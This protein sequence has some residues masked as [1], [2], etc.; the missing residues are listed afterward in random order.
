MAIIGH[1][2]RAARIA[3]L[4]FAACLPAAAGAETQLS[5]AALRGEHVFQAAAGCSC[6]TD[7][8]NDGPP[9]AGG[10]ALDTP[11]GTF[12][13]PNITPHPGT[14][15]GNWDQADFVRAMTTGTG[16]QGVHYY[17]AFPYTSYTRMTR[18]DLSDLWAYLATREPVERR[19]REHDLAWPFSWRYLLSWWQWWYL[20]DPG[21]AADAVTDPARSEQWNRGAYLVNGPSHCG[22]CHTPRGWF[23]GLDHSMAL[24]GTAQGPEGEL[25]P[26]ITPDPE[27]GIGNWTQADLAWLLQTGLLP[28][29]DSVQGAMAEAI[30]QGYSALPA[31][32]RNAIAA[33]LLA[34]PPIHNPLQ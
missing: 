18:Q 9:L 21:P 20:D 22:E 30:D 19:N 14:G 24:A 15:L 1:R 28:D 29:G 6:H 16:P 2:H 12:Y 10:R 27:T 25:V 17:P 8:P 7:L 4:V 34:R 11:F 3:A 33:Y 31:A 32:D 23:G 26:N 5:D 13:S